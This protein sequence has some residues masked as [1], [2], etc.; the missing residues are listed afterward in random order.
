MYKC[1][2]KLPNGDEECGAEYS[3]WD[4]LVRHHNGA[5]GKQK[6]AAAHPNCEQRPTECLLKEAK[7]FRPQPGASVISQEGLARLNELMSVGGDDPAESS[8]LDTWRTR[9]RMKTRLEELLLQL[10]TSESRQN[11]FATVTYPA[12]L[13]QMEINRC[14]AQPLFFFGPFP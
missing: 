10:D 4:G 8:T 13:D 9:Q 14:A 7:N 12:A 3:T 1:R 11:F 2:C 6:R 5:H